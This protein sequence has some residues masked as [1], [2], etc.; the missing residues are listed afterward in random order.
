MIL[1]CDW[2]IPHVSIPTKS[3]R[4]D[5]FNQFLMIFAG[6]FQK[7]QAPVKPASA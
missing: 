1:G 2:Q 4:E 5:L 7:L 3:N 6:S